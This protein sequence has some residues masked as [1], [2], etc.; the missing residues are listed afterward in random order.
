MTVFVTIISGVATFVLGQIL[1]KL[2]IEPVHEFRRTVADIALAL[3]EYANIYANPGVAGEEVEKLASV[4]LRKLSSRLHAQMYLIPCY[5]FTSKVF[6]LPSG[7]K[8]RE[9]A[10]N[11]IGLSNGLSK[12]SSDLISANVQR[13]NK[14]HH[15][16][17]IPPS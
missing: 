1:L 8:V 15:L 2:L 13:A 5:S 17:G 3:I 9:V 7:D 4:N 10:S 11:I 14:I 6:R 12:S 16:L